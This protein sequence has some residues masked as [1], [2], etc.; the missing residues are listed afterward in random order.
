MASYHDRFGSRRARALTKLG[1]EV[2]LM[3][4]KDVKAYVKRLTR[5]EAICEA[6]RRPSMRL[7][8]PKRLDL[9]R[10][11]GAPSCSHCRARQCSRWGEYRDYRVSAGVALGRA[12]GKPY[13]RRRLKTQ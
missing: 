5:M 11:L 4:A 10:E 1:H 6:V 9:L 3:P 2:H 13:P 8:V 7:K 12:Y